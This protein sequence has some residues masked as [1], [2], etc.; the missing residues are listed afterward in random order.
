VRSIPATLPG[1]A[2][3]SI[4]DPIDGTEEFIHG[5]PTF[6]A[7]RALHHHGVP[8]VG[9]IDHPALDVRVDAAVGRGAYR[10]GRRIHLADAPD[11]I[12]H[13][14]VRLVMTARLNFTREVDEGHL[15]EA[16]TRAYA[17]HRIYRA[18][19]AQTV[20]VSG[21]ADAMVDMHNH[22]WD[23]AAAEILIEEAGGRY[24]IVRDFPGADG[25]RLISAVFGRPGIV[26][27]LLALLTG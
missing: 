5:I 10:N 22:I 13:E 1:S 19:Y 26:E 7:M 14:A 25:S 11:D 2:F 17:N 24:A 15:F 12:R 6:G 8:V 23:L 21:A 4:L 18:A 3:Q 20:V 27:R 16:L 9:V